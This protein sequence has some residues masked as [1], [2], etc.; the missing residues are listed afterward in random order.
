MR[1]MPEHLDAN[2]RVPVG[3]GWVYNAYTDTAWPPSGL[4]RVP[5]P[6]DDARV[7]LEVRAGIAAY[8]ETLRAK[9]AEKKRCP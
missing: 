8:V 2:L 5:S 4:V 7:P 6:E 9:I 1:R 3:S